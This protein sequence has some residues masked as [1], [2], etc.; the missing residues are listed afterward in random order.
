M[1]GIRWTWIGLQQNKMDSVSSTLVMGML[2]GMEVAWGPRIPM[3][4]PTGLGL[5]PPMTSSSDEATTTV[6]PVAPPSSLLRPQEVA[7][8]L[9]LLCILSSKLLVPILRPS[10]H[11]HLIK[12]PCAKVKSITALP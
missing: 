7:I 3:V 4:L 11:Q 2:V 12:I 1:R 9:D 5:A 8:V 10:R 6:R